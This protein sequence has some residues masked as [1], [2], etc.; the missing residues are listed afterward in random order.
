MLSERP[1]TEPM[2]RPFPP[3]HIVMSNA[4]MRPLLG[5]IRI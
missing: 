3:E 4:E 2:E 1:P 5:Y